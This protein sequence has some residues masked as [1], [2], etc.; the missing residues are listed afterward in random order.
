MRVL[1]NISQDLYDWL[2]KYKVILDED[3]SEIANA[4]ADGVPLKPIEVASART[5]PDIPER[6]EKIHAD[7]AA[8]DIPVKKKRVCCNCRHNV[9]T[10]DTTGM[11]KCNCDIDGHY[12]GYVECF[13][14]WCN[15]WSKG[16]GK[17]VHNAAK[18]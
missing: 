14:H 13:E 16:V 6:L 15:H 11:I 5:K 8:A 2:K 17:E 12:I 7:I 18:K 10:K 9:R 3:F 4:I 1:I